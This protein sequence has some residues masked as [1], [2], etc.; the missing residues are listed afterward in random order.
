MEKIVY[1]STDGRYQ[2]DLTPVR[3]QYGIFKTSQAKDALIYLIDNPETCVF[4]YDLV[5][6]DEDNHRM[7]TTLYN[8]NS[9]MPF[10][11]VQTIRSNRTE[12]DYK[13]YNENFILLDNPKK[14]A[15]VLS[16]EQK[17][18]RRFNRTVWPLSAIF[19]HEDNPAV[20][21]SG[22]VLSL[23]AGG[24]FIK[25]T[26]LSLLDNETVIIEIQ[27]M[28]FKFL[29]EAKVVRINKELSKDLPVGFAVE[30]IKISEATKRYIARLIKDRILSTLLMDMEF[31][32]VAEE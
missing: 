24:A 27:F 30:F 11:G 31:E 10:I 21:E 8:L 13:L 32:P 25:T 1:L 20:S 3:D 5:P 6:S 2:L 22:V 23:S 7:L 9:L 19:Y 29:V 17:N 12:F 18:R 26:N 28:D 4:I 16:R 14:I 15:E